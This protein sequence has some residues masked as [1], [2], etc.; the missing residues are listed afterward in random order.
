M[1]FYRYFF[2]F[3]IIFTLKELKS[4]GLSLKQTKYND[5]NLP[6]QFKTMYN[7]V[8]QHI[9]IYYKCYDR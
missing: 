6:F 1:S 7:I 9:M 8:F 5:M 3:S 2:I 4:Q